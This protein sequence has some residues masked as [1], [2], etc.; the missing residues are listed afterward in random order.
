MPLKNEA[1]EIPFSIRAYTKAE[2][3]ALYNPTQ[4]ITVALKTLARWMRAHK[5]LMQ[6][7]EEAE[8]NKYRKSFTP[9][10]VQ[11]LVKHLGEPG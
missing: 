11:I 5:A 4:C 8:Y 10:E 2:L 6:E 7:M 1:K 3:A 9:R